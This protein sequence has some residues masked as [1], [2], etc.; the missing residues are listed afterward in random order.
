MTA[1]RPGFRWAAKTQ[2]AAAFCLAGAL[3]GTGL[4]FGNLSYVTAGDDAARA[5]AAAHK[6]QG[7]R[8]QAAAGLAVLLAQSVTDRTATDNAFN[9]VISCR[10]D[11]SAPPGISPDA[12]ATR[13]AL[14]TVL[15]T[16]PGRAT[17]PPALLS[18]LSKAWEA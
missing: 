2:A 18:D 4:Y 8:G 10:P 16:M 12:A 3:V 15:S 13:R 14:L 17:L 9:D 6:D 1:G 7:A 11:L 5:A